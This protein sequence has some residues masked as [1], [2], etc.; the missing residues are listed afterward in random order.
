MTLSFLR[1]RLLTIII[2][3][4][5]LFLPLLR[6]HVVFPTGGYE[7]VYYRPAF[8]LVDYFQ[9]QDWYPFLL[10]LGFSAF[11]YAVVS[12]VLAFVF[13]VI[14]PKKKQFRRKSS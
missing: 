3:L 2:S 12:G 9:M 8:L 7:I 13:A 6:E 5:A 4:I 11:I 14:K 1:P 10:M